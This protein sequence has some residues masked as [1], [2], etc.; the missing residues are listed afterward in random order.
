VAGDGASAGSNAS[1]NITASQPSAP[2]VSGASADNP[3][4]AQDIYGNTSAGMFRPQWEDP[5][6]TSQL[7]RYER[8]NAESW[9]ELDEDW[10]EIEG[11]RAAEPMGS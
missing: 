2:T 9:R 11:H 10:D 8:R 4:A 5:N 6:A 3:L 1:T 7:P